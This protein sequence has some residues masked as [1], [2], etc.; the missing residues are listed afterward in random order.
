MIDRRLLAYIPSTKKYI[1]LNVLAQWISLLAN[2]VI[3]YTIAK[4]LAFLFSGSDINVFSYFMIIVIAIIIKAI[5]NVFSNKMAFKATS[6][7]K[8]TFREAILAKLLKIKDGYHKELSSAEVTQITTEGVDQL[9]TYYGSYIPQ[10]FYAILAPLTLFLVV[11]PID[12]LTALVLFICVPLIPVTIIVIQRWAKRLLSKYWDSYT[13]LGDSFL[14]DLEGLVTLKLFGSDLYKQDEMDKEAENFRVITMKVLSMQL[15]SITVMDLVAYGG[16]ALGIILALLA[17]SNNAISLVEVIFVILISADFFLPMRLLGSFFHIAMNGMAAS[18]KIFRLLDMQDPTY[19][20]MT[21]G[22]DVDIVC[23]HITK[24]YDDRIVLNDINLKIK[25][26][27][28]VGIVGVS[29]SGKSTL[30]KILNGD[31]GEY[32]GDVYY[33]DHKLL[34]IDPYDLKRKVTYVANDAY[35]FSGNV[36][37]NLTMG[38]VIDD[39]KLSMALNKVKL[40]DHFDT[41]EGLDTKI[42]EGGSDLS[43]GQRQRLAIARALVH[44]SDI[45]ILDEATS[46]IDMESEKAIIDLVLS[47]KGQKT[48]ILISH[49]LANV[50]R[51]DVIYCLKDG[52]IE[53][54]GEHTDLI[55][56]NGEYYKLY[57]EQKYYEDFMIGE[58]A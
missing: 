22:D 1:Y 2:I 16:A 48:I 11:L 26:N 52:K 14:E 27:S 31:I 38:K 3:M 40:K 35:I 18:S 10:F 21:V 25:A 6:L 39:D 5:A 28:L 17:F 53:E 55:E 51:A 34:D 54:F 15:N 37:D 42:K 47:L 57:S 4:I 43:G 30:A 20:E 12:F 49:R 46:N 29:G 7:V 58:K 50:E 41:L 33:G 8:V 32:Q 13:S 9:E 36:R 44:D 45:Y 24:E 19:G 56:A 23:D